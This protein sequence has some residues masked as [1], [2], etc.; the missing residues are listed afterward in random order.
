MT[1]LPLNVQSDKWVW[2]IMTHGRVLRHAPQ[3][4]KMFLSLLHFHTAT[5][6]SSAS[7][8]W[9]RCW[10]CYQWK[11]K[12]AGRSKHPPGYTTEQRKLV[13]FPGGFLRDRQK[14]ETS[15]DAK[16]VDH[17]MC[18]LH[19]EPR[20]ETVIVHSKAPDVLTWHIYSIIK[21]HQ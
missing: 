9:W 4:S 17:K 14:N 16:A 5:V 21:M 3:R 19:N 18:K 1:L 10:S 11:S 12:H 2:I 6:A 15:R 13:A 8:L 20:L 7:S